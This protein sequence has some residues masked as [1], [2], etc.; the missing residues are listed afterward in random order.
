MLKYPSGVGKSVC[1]SRGCKLTLVE[2]FELA[3]SLSF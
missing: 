2:L 1:S 3:F